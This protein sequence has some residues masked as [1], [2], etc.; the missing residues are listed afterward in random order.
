MK[1]ITEYRVESAQTAEKLIMRVEDA[2]T[3]GWEPQG[4]VSVAA[5]PNGISF[6]QAMVR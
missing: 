1:K 6:H 5:G 2:L 4:G 3:I